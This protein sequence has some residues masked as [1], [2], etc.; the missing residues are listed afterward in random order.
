MTPEE[1]RRLEA[2]ARDVT[3]AETW[4][5]AETEYC[6]RRARSLCL[7][8]ARLRSEGK[9]ADVHRRCLWRENHPSDWELL[10]DRR[11]ARRE[12]MGAATHPR[13]LRNELGVTLQ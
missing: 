2:T 3:E 9:P 7:R 12:W 13:W 1:M 6:R 5:R 11:R 4:F 8:C 10:R